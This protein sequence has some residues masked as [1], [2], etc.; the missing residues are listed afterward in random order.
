[1]N[2]VPPEGAPVCPCRE[3]GGLSSM[4]CPTGHLL[5]CH[6]PLGCDMAACGHLPRYYE[7]MT[8]AEMAS[9]EELAEGALRTLA[10]ADCPECQSAGMLQVAQDLT[11]HDGSTLTI[12][13]IAVCSCVAATVAADRE[14]SS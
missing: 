2:Y 14:E 3:S 6:Y 13:A 12:S 8:E 5:E 1:M 9:R 10:R 11:L 4:F 7:D